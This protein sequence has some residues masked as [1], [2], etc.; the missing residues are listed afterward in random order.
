V[1]GVV[2]TLIMVVAAFRVSEFLATLFKREA[3]MA[4]VL[5]GGSWRKSSIFENFEIWN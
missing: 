3:L 5:F 2:A 1:V 4:V